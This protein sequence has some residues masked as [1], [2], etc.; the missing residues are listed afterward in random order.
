MLLRSRERRE[1]T[2]ELEATD[3]F[4]RRVKQWE[5]I[6]VSSGL[7]ERTDPLCPTGP[8]SAFF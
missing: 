1:L 2:S 5:R 8:E 3:D 4:D 7:R 6:S